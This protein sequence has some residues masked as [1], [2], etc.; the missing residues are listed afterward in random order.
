MGTKEQEVI[1]N[2]SEIEKGEQLYYTKREF[3]S[4][5]LKVRIEGKKRRPEERPGL[6][7]RAEQKEKRLNYNGLARIGGC[8]S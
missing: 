5:I 6:S 1:S 8:R 4:I 2:S 7:S 3:S